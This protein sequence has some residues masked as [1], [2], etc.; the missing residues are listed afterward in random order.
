MPT[1]KDALNGARDI[2]AEGLAENAA[3]LGDLRAFMQAEARLTSKVIEGQ[4][5]AGAKFSDYFDHVEPWSKVPSHRALAM[6][7]AQKEGI[8]TLDIAPEPEEG[9]ARAEAL[10]ASY[11]ETRTDQP[12]DQWLRK[13]AGW[14]WRVKLSLTMMVELMGDLRARAQDEAIAVFA[15]NLKDL[16]FAAPAGARPTLGLD[17]G[18]RTGVKAAVV[19]A[20]GKLVATDT[21]YPFQPKNDLRGAQAAIMGMI[22]RHGV[23]LIAIGNGT[24]SPR[25]RASGRRYAGDAA[26][27]CAET[28][29]GGGERGRRLGLF[30]LGTGGAGISGSGRQPARARSPSPG[31]YRIR[32][33]NWSRSNRKASAS[34]STSTTSTSTSWENRSRR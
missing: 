18:I 8:V 30:R 27:R 29:Q 6:L 10:V 7:R 31:G 28:N 25:N 14:T 21:L 22:A 12:G 5:Q 16:L 13:I 32:W 9:A 3:L 4:E 34:A 11:L 26:L 17:P 23:E 20:T 2:I 1:V 33:P 24:A 19:D 15:R